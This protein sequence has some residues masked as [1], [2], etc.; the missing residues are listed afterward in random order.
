MGRVGEVTKAHSRKLLALRKT[1]IFQ[2]KFKTPD[3]RIVHTF[4]QFAQEYL[5]YAKGNK[6]SWIGMNAPCDV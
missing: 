6:K 1:E 4:A 3:K 2:G 5:E